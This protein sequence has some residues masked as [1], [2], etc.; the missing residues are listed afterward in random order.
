MDKRISTSS[1]EEVN[2]SIESI[3]TDD[4]IEDRREG[5]TV[6][7]DKIEKRASTN[8]RQTKLPAKLRDPAFMLNRSMDTLEAE[9]RDSKLIT[10]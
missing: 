6:E 4:S 1:I 8:R 5:T 10:S 3:A 2:S 9:M 7:T